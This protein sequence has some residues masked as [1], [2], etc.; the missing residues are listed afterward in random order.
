MK[1]IVRSGNFSGGNPVPATNPSFNTNP[2]PA[3]N[4]SF[5]T[6]PIPATDPKFNTNVVD[7]LPNPAHF[8]NVISH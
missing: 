2:V 8:G 6:N 7:W 5:N 3:T 4:P 1:G